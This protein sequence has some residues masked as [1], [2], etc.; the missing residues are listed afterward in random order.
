MSKPD[1]IDEPSTSTR[2]A[3]RNRI[4][5]P[6]GTGVGLLV[7][8]AVVATTALMGG[9][10]LVVGAVIPELA[11]V[12]SPPTPYLEGSPFSSYLVPGLILG[13]VVGGLHAVAF[14]LGVR[15]NDLSLLAAAV[16]AIALLIWVFVQMAF[17]P[18]SFLQAI[19][20]AI[21]V[22]ETILILLALGILQ[23]ITSPPD[24]AAPR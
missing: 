10:A 3:S 19:Y 4:R 17:I 1:M 5:A 18:F 14:A 6:R 16:A 21:A 15:R 11:T 24:R 7:L 13:L 20:F 12:L 2:V 22:A 9:A 23:S 8:Q